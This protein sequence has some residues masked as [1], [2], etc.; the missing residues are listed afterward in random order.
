MGIFGSAATGVDLF[1][2]A[3]VAEAVNADYASG[4]FQTI[5]G[6]WLRLSGHADYHSG[7]HSTG[8]MVRYIVG[9]RYARDVYDA[10]HGR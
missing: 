6:F 2:N 7:Y 8:V 4:V 9:F 3:G 10:L 5:A 1:Y